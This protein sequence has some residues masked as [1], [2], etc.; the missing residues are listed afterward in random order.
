MSGSVDQYAMFLPQRS[1][2]S[3]R[4]VEACSTEVFFVA[5]PLARACDAADVEGHVILDVSRHGTLREDI[6]DGHSSAPFE[7]SKHLIEDELFLVFRH[8][9]DDAVADHAVDA[10]VRQGDLGDW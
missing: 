5:V 9:V 7:T 8:E 6:A 4:T 1:Y 3:R 2:C 10:L